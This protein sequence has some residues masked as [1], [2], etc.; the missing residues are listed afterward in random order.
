ME[1]DEKLREY[2]KSCLEKGYSLESI[3][4]TL[5][6]VGW[7][8]QEVENAINSVKSLPPPPPAPTSKPSESV[9]RPSG[10]TII[11]IIGFLFSFFILFLGILSVSF[12]EMFS[13]MQIPVLQIIGQETGFLLTILGVLFIIISLTGFA[14]FYLLLKMK[15]IGWIMVSIIGVIFIVQSL[16][17]F[18]LINILIIAIWVLILY[19]LYRKRE[20]FKK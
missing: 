8:E 4:Q 18:T 14:A 13:G 3:K 16:I 11:C 19:Y 5:L 7:S 2:I 20:L 10:I 9:T 17:S 15:K 1:N 6:N 12:I